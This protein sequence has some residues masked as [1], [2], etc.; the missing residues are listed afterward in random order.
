MAAQRILIVGRPGSGRKQ[1]MIRK[2]LT[3]QTYDTVRV[4]LPRWNPLYE[5]MANGKTYRSAT[6]LPKLES[7]DRTKKHLVV[8]HADPVDW[9]ECNNIPQLN[10]Y[11]Q[12]AAS[13]GITCICV[14]DRFFYLFTPWQAREK[15]DIVCMAKSNASAI[16]VE[17][18][19]K[20]HPDLS[21]TQFNDV[22]QIWR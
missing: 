12:H 16:N 17:S 19:R 10:E 22:W 13:Y 8:L 7:F 18:I 3:D 1:I 4:V 11:W 9:M 2:F 5:A 15:C 21:V 6:Q 20:E 14:A